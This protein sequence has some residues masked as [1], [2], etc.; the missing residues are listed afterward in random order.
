M[1]IVKEKIEVL[2]LKEMAKKM[3]DNLVK[4]MVDVEKE[5]MAALDEAAISRGSIEGNGPPPPAPDP[6]NHGYSHH[7]RV[8][9]LWRV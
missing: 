5:I 9:Q 1:K 7:F 8:H 6:E 3:H 4:A 2:E